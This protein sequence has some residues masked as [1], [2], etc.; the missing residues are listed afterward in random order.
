MPRI[1]RPRF[2]SMRFW[3]R[4][5]STRILPG[6]NWEAIKTDQVG[7][8]GYIGYKVGMVSVYVKDDTPDSMTKGKRIT[9]PAT[10]I[11]CPE[12]KIFSVRFY[13][14]KKIVGEFVVSND[15]VLKKILKVPK[16]VKKIDDF[17][18]EFD[19]VRIL[20]YTDLSGGFFKKT[21]DLIELGL[22]GSEQ[23][24]IN[25]VKERLNKAI[26]ISDLVESKV[27]DVRGV[28]KGY[29]LQGPVKRFGISLKAHKSEK[30]VRRPGSLGPWH[31]AR[32][33]F[34]TPLAG[35]TGFHTRIVYN[36]LVLKK[37]KSFE[38]KINPASGFHKYGNLKK[39]Y[40][41]LKGSVQGPTKRQLLLTSPLR[42]TK[43]STKKK[44]EFIETR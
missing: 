42:T 40:I 35:Q 3:P 37:G 4:K 24:K 10:V 5:R 7:L 38:D 14:N 13:K 18:Q 23:D 27:I 26:S 16:Q 12:I 32:V 31:P 39:D 43:S 19:D 33:N 28:T 8:K 22:S 2:G 29:G 11:E 30:G 34:R 17:K 44:Y 9:I 20:A 36:S 41:L 15:K 1:N 6:V 21:P 25:F